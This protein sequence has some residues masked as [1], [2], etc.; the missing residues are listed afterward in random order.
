[1]KNKL[2]NVIRKGSSSVFLRRF[3][4]RRRVWPNQEEFCLAN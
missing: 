1:M 3:G 4:K 2:N